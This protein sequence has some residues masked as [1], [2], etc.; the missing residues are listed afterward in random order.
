MTTLTR[1][2]KESFYALFDESVH[3]AIK[4]CVE[5][6]GAEAMVVFENRQMDSSRFGERGALAVGFSCSLKTVEEA[7][8]QRLGDAPSNFK[9][10]IG[11]IPA[12]ELL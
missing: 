7:S 1:Y 10:P 3:D 5:S 9:Y 6:T 2:D 8:E 11:W 12:K 4:A